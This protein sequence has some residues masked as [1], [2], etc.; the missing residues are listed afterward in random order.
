MY[1]CN[2]CGGKNMDDAKVCSYCG[3]AR[4]TS[5]PADDNFSPKQK[6]ASDVAKQI[7]GQID[8]LGGE[9]TD[10]AM[11]ILTAAGVKLYY[12]ID[13]EKDK[14]GG[15]KIL[16]KLALLGNVEAMFRIAQLYMKEE[17]ADVN[18]AKYWFAKAAARGHVAAQNMLDWLNKDASIKAEKPQA[19]PPKNGSTEFERLVREALSSVVKIDSLSPC[20]QNGRLCARASQG[21][22]FII[23]GGYVVTNAHVVDGGKEIYATFDEDVS[24]ERYRLNLLKSE[25]K[26]DVA[27]LRFDGDMNEKIMQ[28]AMAGTRK[29]FSLRTTPLQHGEEVYTVG[30]PLGLGISVNKGIVS[31]PKAKKAGANALD[32]VIQTNISAHHGNSGGGLIDM[33]NAAVG[34][35]S[36][37]PAATAEGIKPLNDIPQELWGLANELSKNLM[38]G[39]AGISYA[40]PAEYILKVLKTIKE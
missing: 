17:I 21:A 20:I 37:G 30:N 3:A 16:D 39:A 32:S 19:S 6:S 34:I 11:R 18:S 28:E 38:I 12:G 31:N 23:E 14:I 4:L 36:S 7:L 15:R 24:E 1:Q 33:N 13:I 5:T 10:E 27:I 29:M 8:V 22:G 35:L 9:L 40:I 26:Y 2:F 25:E